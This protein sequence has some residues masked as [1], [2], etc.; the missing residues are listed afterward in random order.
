MIQA[1]HFLVRHCVFVVFGVVFLDQLG[2]PLPAVP[3]L[4]AAGAVSAKEKWRLAIG[5]IAIVVACLIADAIWFYVG[6]YR[7]NQVL[8]LLC[9]L[10][11]EPDSCVRR[12]RNI[13]QKYG[14]RGLVAAKFL[15]GM[16]TV[17]PPLAGLSGMAAGRFFVV[18]S[19]GSLLYGAFFLGF[20]YCFSSQ[21]GHLSTA[22]SRTEGGVFIL[23]IAPTVL[24]LT[25][26]WVQRQSL[27][28]VLRAPR[29]TVEE[30]R[31]KLDANESLLVLDVRS[32]AALRQD[33][34]LIPGAIHQSID[35][36][37]SNRLLVPWD[38][39]IVVYCCCPNEVSSAEI[40]LQLQRR[41]FPR[42]RPLLGGLEAWKR[43]SYPLAHC[44]FNA[45]GPTETHPPSAP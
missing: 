20:G 43:N 15:P 10:S 7:G 17:A 38:R 45:V 5:L 6:R 37:E 44:V 13:F 36:I 19:L 41:G 26:K 3:W 31:Q 40:A 11:L 34:V 22:L 39:D 23:I 27:Q 1:T 14:L 25:C 30:L 21:I 16:S 12:A 4:L 32:H 35:D 33:P 42:V 29:I 18:D 28:R 9:R 8:S 2:L 24:L